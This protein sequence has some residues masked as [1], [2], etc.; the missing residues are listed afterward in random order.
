MDEGVS[1]QLQARPAVGA[2][3]LLRVAVERGPDA[4][5]GS[6]PEGAAAVAVGSSPDNGL[7]LADPLVSRYHLELRRAA[8]GIAVTDLGST[9]GTWLGGVRLREAVV[10]PGSR[11]Q[12]GDTV[13]RV[14]DAGAR[15]AAPAETAELPG[16]VAASEPMRELCRAAARLTRVT[17]SVLIEGE[18]GAGKEV[19][20]RALHEAGPR[21]D[22][23][24]VVVDCGSLPATLIASQL[25]GHERGAFT[26]ADAAR[27]G[28]FERA[29]GGTLLLD[30]VGELPLDLQP[31]LLGV[32]ERR[33]F[34]RV[35]GSTE[36][37]VD[38]R[39]LAATNR[40]LR[41]EVNAGSFR[42]DLYYR[43]AVARLLVPPLRDR[44]ADLEPLIGRFV[45]VITGS[46][47]ANPLAG[48]MEALRRHRFPGNVR[49]LR[50]LVEAVLVLGRI[51]LDGHAAAP[52]P[53][54]AAEL[55]P[56]KDARAAA[57]AAFEADYLRHLLDAAG[58]NVSEAARRARMDRPYLS[59]LLK[60]HGLR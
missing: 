25:F 23:P 52:A 27:A 40:D 60:K 51:D 33:R 39:V 54:A 45:E 26:G 20:A 36:L 1:T 21:R 29:D 50:N 38:V 49:E 53:G 3:R 43:L 4:G 11:L 46:P 56:Y 6:D 35:G 37:A 48:A 55:L 12:I 24:F 14:D 28:A 8:D 47:G 16:L 18:T 30:E 17:T 32:I 19:I 9:N 31:A 7:V 5:A 13:L 10:P 2:V 57:L 58:G 22:R 44:A 34:V 41:A 42:A 15:A 59:T